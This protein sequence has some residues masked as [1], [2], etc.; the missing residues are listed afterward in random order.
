MKIKRKGHVRKVVMEAHNT[1]LWHP[2]I[3]SHNVWLR[4]V[5]GII[6]FLLITC[7]TIFLYGN[8]KH[9]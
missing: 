9:K 3:L 8:K 5:V 4:L 7:L 6:F 2:F 1:I